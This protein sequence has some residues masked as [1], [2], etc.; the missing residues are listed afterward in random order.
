MEG[1]VDIPIDSD[2]DN[3]P[4]LSV[5]VCIARSVEAHSF[6]RGQ[7][8]RNH[9]STKPDIDGNEIG[10]ESRAYKWD[11]ADDTGL[12]ADEVHQRSE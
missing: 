4:M 2:E 5:Q 8:R 6:P 10:E 7:S 11:L 3:A 9:Q 12:L 1:I